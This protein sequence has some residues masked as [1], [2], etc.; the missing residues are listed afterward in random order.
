MLWGHGDLFFLLCI[1]REFLRF[2]PAFPK[3]TL[4]AASLTGGALSPRNPKLTGMRI[5]LPSHVCPPECFEHFRNTKVPIPGSGSLCA[6]SGE[7]RGRNG[8]KE[9]EKKREKER[10]RKRKGEKGR[11]GQKES[12]FWGSLHTQGPHLPWEP[13]R[14]PRIRVFSSRD[15]TISRKEFGVK[16]TLVAKQSTPGFPVPASALSQAQG[17]AQELP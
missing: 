13:P 6:G 12:P 16:V 8:E 10:G 4:P 11:K 5:Y 2:A 15:G 3:H 7:K 1:Q 9:I 14:P 17:E